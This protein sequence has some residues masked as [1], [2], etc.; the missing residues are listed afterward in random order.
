V[1]L[2]VAEDHTFVREVL[3]DLLE[4]EPDFEVVGAAGDGDETVRMTVELRPDILLLDLDLPGLSGVA[5]AHVLREKLPAL[6]IMVLTACAERDRQRTMIRLGVRGYLSKGASRDELVSAV[7][8]VHAGA[9]AFHSDVVGFLAGQAGLVSA[10]APTAR[11]LSV[12]R[13]VAG[14]LKNR[15]IAARMSV[16]EA[17]VEFHLH[18]LFGKF[19]AATRTD[20]VQRARRD[21]W[22]A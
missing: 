1:R 4:S 2:V 7:R 9:S 16:A 22:V 8:V 20:L 12:L 11:E 19:D 3:R 14:G 5:V 17:T 18:N 6:R 15:D 13:L 10:P 21:G